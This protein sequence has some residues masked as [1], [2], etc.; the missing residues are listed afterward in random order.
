MYNLRLRFAL[1]AFLVSTSPFLSLAS[2]ASGTPLE[3][4]GKDLR[5]MSPA[6][7]AVKV[8]TTD[9]EHLVV[10]FLSAKCP[11]SISHMEE[12]KNLA[13]DFPEFKFVAMIAPPILGFDL[14]E[15]PPLYY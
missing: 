3:F 9:A 1:F 6:S 4:S 13:K 5:Q 14:G 2:G 8:A 15:I 12:V 11:C 7:P 10:L